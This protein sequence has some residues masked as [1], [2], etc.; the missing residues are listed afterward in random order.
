MA[1]SIFGWL[2]QDDRERLQMMEIVNLFREQSTLDELGTAQIRDGFSDHFFPGTSTIQTRARYFLFVPWIQLQSNLEGNSGAEAARR[3]RILHG[4]LVES[5]ISGGESSAGIIGL[6][7]RGS[8]QRLPSE[9]YWTGLSAWGI[10]LSGDSLERYDELRQSS[11]REEAESRIAE[12]GELVAQA[13]RYWH[14]GLP[15]PPTD[16][17]ERASFTLTREEA[18]FLHERIMASCPGT[19]LE[20]CLSNPDANLATTSAPWEIPKLDTLDPALQE[21]IEHARRFA[22][23]AEGAVNLYN[24]MLAERSRELLAASDDGDRQ[25]DREKRERLVNEYTDRFHRWADEVIAER[26]ALM[27]W[28]RARFWERARVFRPTLRASTELFFDQWIEMAIENP[29]SLF[30][31][32]DA[33]R[34]ISTRERRLKGALARLHYRRPLEQWSGASGLGRMSFRW[35]VARRHVSDILKGLSRG[36]EVDHA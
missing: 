32:A 9:I 24:L 30:T 17:F 2:D 31:S 26:E 5:L 15:G 35:Q 21:D 11:L 34:L 3:E 23:L 33:R 27:Y 20:G 18:E 4:Q 19:L 28:D 6:Y 13:P 25:V 12:S 29:R 14:P 22:L 16:L 8:L 10:R 7:A 36:P 1:T